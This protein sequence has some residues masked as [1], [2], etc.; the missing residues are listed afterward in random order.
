MHV[1]P[2]TDLGMRRVRSGVY[3]GVLGLQHDTYLQQVYMIFIQIFWCRFNAMTQY[4]ADNVY[5][6]LSS[7]LRCYCGVYREL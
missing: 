2:L 3:D 7:Y 1:Q 4:C 6:G 5:Y